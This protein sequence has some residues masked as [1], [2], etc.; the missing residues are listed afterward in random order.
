MSREES[1]RSSP[2]RWRPLLALLIGLLWLA[3]AA[4]VLVVGAQVDLAKSGTTVRDLLVLGGSIVVQIAAPLAVVALAVVALRRTGR[5]EAALIAALEERQARAAEANEALRGGIDHADRTLAQIGARIAELQAAT[6]N[7]GRGLTATARSLE[8]AA[9]T[10]ATAAEAAGTQATALHA[11]IDRA[12]ARATELGLV[13]DRTGAETAGQLANVETLLAAVWNRNADAA[14][15]V[16]AASAQMADLLAGIEAAAARATTAVGARAQ[17]LDASVDGALERTTAA[18]DATRDGVHAQTNALLASVDQARV[19]L[20]HIGGESARAIGKR[21]DRLN[22]AADLLGQRLSEQDARSRM[23]V[24]TVE[25]SFTILDAK[26]GQA[27]AAS[28]QTLDGIAAAMS[29]ITGRV[30]GMNQPLGDTHAAMLTIEDR[31]GRLREATD[32]IGE[33]LGRVLPAHGSSLAALSDAVAQLHGETGRLHEPVAAGQAALQQAADGVAGQRALMEATVTQ[34]TAQ[35]DHAQTQIADVRSAAEGGALAAS[36]QLI[37]VLGRV[38]EIAGTTAGEMR[39][40]L[41][42]VIGEAHVA[43]EH[44]G[45][46]HA[47]RTFGQPIRAQLAAI[48]EASHRAADA[49]Q[50]AADRVA[51]RLVGLTKTVAAVEARI[52]EVQ[53]HLDV[54]ARDDLM[55]RSTRLVESLNAAS[56][57]I[58]KLLAIEVGD[59]S[60]GAYLAGDRSVFTRRV[61]RLADA[62]TARA[63]KRHYVHDTAFRELAVQYIDEFE[64]LIKH[65]DADKDG[66][67]LAITLLS[68]DV[69]KLYV[70]LAQAIER[71]R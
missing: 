63:V 70:V 66:R 20:D 48:E 38:R 37:E 19:A 30:N 64:R 4:A 46:T 69:G 41:E 34:L 22:E 23:L 39:S 26:L 2:A 67:A 5:D 50:G 51:N 47:E 31:V 35:L 29:T 59:Q 52:D 53:T 71:L 21:L 28:H 1:T 56:I 3:V 12:G 11:L 54:Q 6:D 45:T 14:A 10:M 16:H 62:A 44:A 25:R 55:G 49:A 57:D 60:W 9:G 18:L 68:S 33:T 27:A 36:T 24:E 32:G 58:A 65:V 17:A 8:A 43:L 15:Q 7:D 13:L 61:V 40:A 42:A